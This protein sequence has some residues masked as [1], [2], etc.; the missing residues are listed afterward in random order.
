MMEHLIDD[1]LSN[2]SP[3]INLLN[4]MNDPLQDDYEVLMNQDSILSSVDLMDIDSCSKLDISA[5]V[6]GEDDDIDNEDDS[7]QSGLSMPPNF[8][9]NVNR[10]SKLAKQRPTTSIYRKL[11]QLGEVK[12]DSN[13]I[14]DFI[15]RNPRHNEPKKPFDQLLAVLLRKLREKDTRR[16]FAWPVTDLLAPGYSQVVSHPMDLSTIEKKIV[17]KL[18]KTVA[19]MKYD[20]RLLCENA[21]RYYRQSGVQYREA[22]KLWHFAKT[23]VFARSVLA[24]TVK[25]FPPLTFADIGIDDANLKQVTSF[26]GTITNGSV[27]AAGQQPLPTAAVVSCEEI[28]SEV[29]KSSDST[30]Q[31]T[32]EKPTGEHVCMLRQEYDGSTSLSIVAD[33][34]N[35]QEDGESGANRA[36]LGQLVGRLSEGTASLPPYVEPESNRIRPYR[37]ATDSLHNSFVSYLP[38]LDSSQSSVSLD[39]TSILLSM[40]GE[41]DNDHHDTIEKVANDFNYMDSFVDSVLTIVSNGQYQQEEEV[42]SEEFEEESAIENGTTKVDDDIERQL[43]ETR[44]LIGQLESLQSA[45]LRKCPEPVVASGKEEEMANKVTSQLVQFISRCALPQEVAD[46]RSLRKAMGIVIKTE[47]TEV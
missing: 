46:V 35:A 45:R 47:P 11:L 21:L 13:N 23:R 4:D 24:E 3:S 41:C 37:L 1:Q 39:D 12:C 32:L 34:S 2:H 15:K 31:F 38:Y 36:T 33:Y 30:E 16:L 20:V 22:A 40:Y 17:H 8:Q 18:Y 25:Q 43:S 7:R 28:L 10:V 14:Y 29:A 26:D 9:L 19:E 5:L 27:G 6:P 44:T 42:K